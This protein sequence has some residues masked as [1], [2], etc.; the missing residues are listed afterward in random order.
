MAQLNAFNAAL[1]CCGFN[2]DTTDAITGE[3]FDTVDVLAKVEDS[4]IESMIKNIRETRRALGAQA[5][6]NVTFP[7]LAIKRFK[8]MHGW[9]AELRRT[10]RPVNAG[11]HAG[12]MMTTAVARFSLDTMRSTITED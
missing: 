8:A 4:D 3:G 9:A 10:G 5:K 12:A 2:A 7:F 6:G 11:L 1:L